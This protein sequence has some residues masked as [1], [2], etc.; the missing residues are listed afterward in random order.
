MWILQNTGYDA[1]WVSPFR[2]ENPTL[3]SAKEL[4]QLFEVMELVIVS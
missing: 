3:K 4:Q 2:W 1:Y